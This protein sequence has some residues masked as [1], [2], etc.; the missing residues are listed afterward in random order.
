MYQNIDRKVDTILRKLT[1]VDDIRRVFECIV[2]RLPVKLPVVS[3]CCQ[4]IV[5]CKE[6][7]SRWL[8][9]TSRCPLC[10]VSGCTADAFDSKGIDELVGFFR[11]GERQ[12][13]DSHS[14]L[15]ET[16][17]VPPVVDVVS[18][19]SFNEFEDLP[20]YNIPRSQYTVSLF[21]YTCMYFHQW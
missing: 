5:G 4:R 10:S 15:V 11:A 3:P 20:N 17:A 8:E 2:C 6:C 12:Q 19:D 9:T 14:Q 21:I 1:F 13:L 18:D 7:V 16:P